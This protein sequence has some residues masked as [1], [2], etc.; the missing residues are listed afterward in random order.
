MSDRP[1]V[2]VETAAQQRAEAR[3]ARDWTTADRLRAQIE[4]AGWKVIDVGT[5]FRLEPAA[6]PDVEVGGEIRYGRSDAVPSRLDEP[7]TG[8]AS[9]ILVASND[10]TE[11]QSAFDALVRFAPD[12]S[13]VVV[14]ADGLPD[15]AL[16]G[17]RG[18]ALAA[19]AGN[20]PVELVRTSAVLGHGAALNA[21]IRRASAATVIAMDPSIIATGDIV[22]PLASALD[23]PTVGVAGPF[24]LVSSDLRRFDEATAAGDAARDVAAVQGYLMAFRRAD[25]IARGPLDEGFRYYRNLDIWW[26]LVLRD[27]GDGAVPRRAVAVPGVPVQRGEPRAW[28]TTPVAERDR[29]SKRNFY[30]VLDR[31]RTR[32][33]LAVS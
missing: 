16:E 3:A 6:P 31:F 29:L 11:T 5:D 30:R 10:P 24:G 20:V 4:D 25:A 28:A 14:V 33:D 19:R 23:D 22:T 32:G 21:G 1:P 17:L 12:G 27:E 9:V 8:L 18:D 13:D 15:R 2:L 26:S 7:A